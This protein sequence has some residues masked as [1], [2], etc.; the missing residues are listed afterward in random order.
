MFVLDKGMRR[1]ILSLSLL[2]ISCAMWGQGS[3]LLMDK[4][5]Q[6]G[7][8]S[9][10]YELTANSSDGRL[11]MEQQG[12]LDIQKMSYRLTSDMLT[13][14]SDGI[15]RWLYSPKS[16]E[17]VICSADYSSSDPLE[18]PLSL[19][20]STSIEQKKDGSFKIV[21]IGANGYVYT[22]LV[23]SISR[24]ET[25]WEE[26]H[27]ILEMDSLPEDVIITDLR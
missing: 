9:L 1:I 3:S 25:P 21:H 16:E 17:L 20:A 13:I 5:S 8:V 23:N 6:M 7:S 18:N 24:R 26:S 10:Q 4:I 2:F 12:T 15:T 22:V 19:L 14:I 27:F 11:L